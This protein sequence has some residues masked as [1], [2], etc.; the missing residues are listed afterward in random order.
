MTTPAWVAGRPVTG[1]ATREVRHPGD[2][3]LV[4]TVAVPSADDVERAVAAADRVARAF[5]STPAHLRAAALD[6]V[7]AQL[8]ARLDEVA[9]D[10]RARFGENGLGRGRLVGRDEVELYPGKS[11]SGR[12][13]S[14]GTR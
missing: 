7:S 13:P 4:G 3:S 14:R 8:R 5:R 12:S 11:P 1:G 9:A 6:H 10:L 2:G